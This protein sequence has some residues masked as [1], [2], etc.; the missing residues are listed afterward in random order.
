M[1]K[2]VDERGQCHQAKWNNGRPT[3]YQK[4]NSADNRPIDRFYCTSEAQGSQQLLAQ[5][6]DRA[7]NLTAHRDTVNHGAVL[8]A[9]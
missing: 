2:F 3:S 6:K 5:R 1:C 7:R 9:Q 4:L 8:E